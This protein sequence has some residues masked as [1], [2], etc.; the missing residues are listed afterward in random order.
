[1]PPGLKLVCALIVSICAA[2]IALARA[3]GGAGVRK[4]EVSD[5]V[6]GRMMD[7][8]AFYPS[9]AEGV[10]DAGPYHVE[11]ARDAEIAA[12][13]YPLILLSHG[14]L[15]SMLGHHDLATALARRGYIVVSLT[16]PGD[17]FR[18]P[19][20]LGA[21]S[22]TLGRPLQISAALTAVLR[23]TLLS[24]H[25]DSTRIGFIGFSAGGE[26]G[27]LLAGAKPDLKRLET[28][29]ASRPDDHHVCEAGGRIRND[30]PDLK[31]AA[32]PRIRA[33]VL[34][35]PLSVVFPEENLKDLRGPFRIYVGENDRELSPEDNAIALAKAL[36]LS[37]ELEILPGAGHF[38]F[39]AP[40]ST[41]LGNTMPLLCTDPSGVDRVAIH[42]KL[43]SEIATFFSESFDEKP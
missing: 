31:P 41:E 7:A 29:C 30:R 24:A 42:R 23:D 5:P 20:G 2:Q 4:F 34:M 22:T 28:Y 17:N 38:V 8:L 13:R 25:A 3:P 18:D 43:V 40:C 1:M 39:L 27:L 19:S 21:T 26:T 10:V 37:P 9:P 14:N 11:A 33:F 32:D 35:A 6:S 15:G 36:S 12:G 16:H